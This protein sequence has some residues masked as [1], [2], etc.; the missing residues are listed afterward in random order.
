M[1]IGAVLL[2]ALQTVALE[3]AALRATGCSVD[4][5]LVAHLQKGTAAEVRFA[6]A[7]ASGAC[8]RVVATVN[9]KVLNGYLPAAALSD[10]A[11]FDRARAQASDVDLPTL[12][13]APMAG[14]R[15][16]VDR[17]P[18]RGGPPHASAMRT[19][20]EMLEDRR[21]E[22]ALALLE[23][24]VQRGVREPRLLA[25]AGIAAYR[26]D[27]LVLA[28]QYLKQSLDLESEPAIQAFYDRLNREVA[29]DKSKEKV[30]GGRF[31][32]RYDGTALNAAVANQLLGMLD[33]EYSRISNHLGCQ[34][35]ERITTILQTRD[36]YFKSS[37]A[38][39]WSGG[40]FD[41]TKIRVPI[42][43]DGVSERTRR[44]LSHEI[45][46]ACLANL[47]SYPAWLHE[48]LAQRLSGERAPEGQ[49]REVREMARSGEIPALS[50]LSG[51]WSGM[52]ARNAR[53]A[54]AYALTA[55]DLLYEKYA[56]YGIQSILRSPPLLQQVVEG[57][58]KEFRR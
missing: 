46:H 4:D 19:A 25:L 56:S 16:A 35:P 21:P 9:G 3:G 7:S 57:L 34:P 27:R 54:Y 32:L 39:E 18:Q 44:V 14:I 41:G 29:N 28:Q 17:E 40:M 52:G 22:Q 36:A 38:V 8:F 30:Y 45:V 1:P 50:A 55:A 10:P 53:I 48:G 47:G 20:M 31:V 23:A 15:A 6:V 24:Q 49:S 58:E 5:E 37:G 33:S 13:Q 51:G 42:D 43:E 11:A 26:A 2:A 12:I